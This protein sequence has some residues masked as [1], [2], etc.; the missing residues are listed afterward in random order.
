[1]R[2]E[3]LQEGYTVGA[4]KKVPFKFD[5]KKDFPAELAKWVGQVFYEVLPEQGYE[6]REE[7]IYTAF[8]IADKVCKKKVHFAEAGLGTGK[9]FAYLLT[10]VAYARFTGKAV[11]IACASTALQEQLV[12]P[13]G[14]LDKL[15]RYL[16]MDIDARMAK[17]P[18]QYICDVRVSRCKSLRFEKQ[19][20]AMEEILSWSDVTKRGE[21]T[22]VPNIPDPIWQQVAWDEGMPCEMCTSRGYCKLVKAKEH[23][24]AARDLIISDHGVFFDD[25]WTRD[26]RIADGKLPLLPA[27]SAVIFDEGHKIMLS[28]AMQAGRQIIKEDLE[29]IVSFIENIQGA[30]TALLSTTVALDLAT[31]RFFEILLNSVI[32]DELTERL[33]VDINDGLLIAAET[34][35]RA[36]EYLQ[37]EMQTEQELHTQTIPDTLLEAYDLRI[38]GVMAALQRLCKNKGI[39]T[40]IWV[41]KI[42]GSFWVVPRDLS[43]ML[44]TNLFQKNLPVVFSS[45]TLSTGGDFSYLSRTLGLTDWSSSSVEGPF[46]FREQVIVYTPESFPVSDQEKWFAQAIKILVS[47]LELSRGRALVLTNSPS[48]V[49]NIRR[50]LKDYHFPFEVLWEDRGERGHLVQKFREVVSSVLVGS[51]FWEGIDVPGE[52][53]SM[54]II[55]QLPFPS[56]DP[57]IEARRREAK[58]AGADP[59]TEVDYPEMGLKLKQGCGRL[60][61]TKDDRGAIVIME[62]F[63]DKPW[64]QF[65]QGALPAGAEVVSNLTEVES[66]LRKK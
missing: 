48:E 23:Y 10:A 1:L 51:G 7:Q 37:G 26:E 22:E 6:V 32:P 54:L 18:R 52:A 66:K 11:V 35:F 47:L 38:E 24:R 49:G 21:R 36:L 13:N 25:L 58:E 17:D 57:L 14:D 34:L 56:R 44:K 62:P 65:V 50:G 12:G 60:I 9:T 43:G 27:Y 33:A 45:A 16:D 5:G 2:W 61:R 15:A 63:R 30:R 39:D 42:D 20:E 3:K 8:Q 28:A 19:S 59:L 41:S 46:D 31:E 40:I 29:Y 4:N 55:W 64:E 53:L